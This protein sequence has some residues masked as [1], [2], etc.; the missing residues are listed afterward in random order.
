MFFTE[1][2]CAKC[3]K[4]FAAQQYHRF[5]EG[6]TYYCT[7]T[8]FNHRNDGEAKPDIMEDCI[9]PE[10]PKKLPFPPLP[11]LKA[12]R[13]QRGMTKEELGKRMGCSRQYI[14]L[15]ESGRARPTVEV[16]GKFVDAFGAEQ[17]KEVFGGVI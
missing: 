7:W 17:T 15:L 1:K 14:Y 5:R 8:C 16:I 11:K 3:G 12:F 4:G 13:E 10:P 2:R 9:A 6:D